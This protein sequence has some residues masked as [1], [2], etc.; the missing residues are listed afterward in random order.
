M[1]LSTKSAGFISID[2]GSKEASYVDSGTGITYT[3]DSNLTRSGEMKAVASDYIGTKPKYLWHLRTFPKGNRNCYTLQPLTPGTS[4]YLLRASFFYGNFDG[5]NLFPEFDLYLENAFV[6]TVNASLSDWE[7]YE[8]IVK[9]RR[10]YLTLCLCRRNERDNPF[11]S[12]IE[13]RPLLGD[14]IYPVVNATLALKTFTRD[15]Y[16]LPTGAASY[17]YPVD[18]F[19]RIWNSAG[20]TGLES[21]N[22]TLSVS[23]TGSQYVPPSIVMQTADTNPN[24]KGRIGS[25]SVI[26]RG[27]YLFMCI[28]FAELKKLEANETREFNL[29]VDSK[30][31]LGDFRPT[32]RATTTICSQSIYPSQNNVVDYIPTERSTLPPIVNALELYSAL[33]LPGSATD[34]GDVGALVDI[35]DKYQITKAWTGDPCLPLNYA[36]EGLVCSND[37]SSLRVLSLNLSGNNLTGTIPIFLAN[38]P[39]LRMLDLSNNDLSGTVPD[40]LL[41]K[42]KDGSLMLRL[43]SSLTL[44]LD[45]EIHYQTAVKKQY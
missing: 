6:H 42:R 15:N 2:C 19:D 38:L 40:D 28:H 3:S 12:A 22:T 10:S 36:W 37:T 35:R 16:G 4:K 29:T 32:Y 25:S 21:I 33:H 34:D 1:I 30:L 13:L 45:V 43:F 31:W 39:Q 14:A 24:P 20:S 44:P 23:S 7:S 11:I 8:M 26:P 27:T 18:A 17:R 9:L 41:R 5:L